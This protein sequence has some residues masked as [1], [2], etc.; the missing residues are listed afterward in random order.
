M[1]ALRGAMT[2]N[3]SVAAT[4]WLALAGFALLA[5]TVAAARLRR[6]WGRGGPM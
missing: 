5:M 1:R 2:G 4:G 6:G 3:L